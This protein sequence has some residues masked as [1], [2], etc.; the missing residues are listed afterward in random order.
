MKRIK[1]FFKLKNW[2]RILISV[3]TLASA[4]S[5]IGFGSKYYVSQNVNK[6]IEYGGGVEVVVQV[7]TNGKVADD[8]LTENVNK[9]LSDRLSGG[10]G[11]N[12]VSV[13]TEGGGKIR[14]TKSGDLNDSQRDQFLKEITNKPILTITDSE[15]KPI[16]YNGVFVEDGSLDRGTPTDWIPP[17]A[18]NQAKNVIQNNGTNV[19]ELALNNQDAVFQWTK[20]TENISKRQNKTVLM[21]LNILELIQLAKTKYASDWAAAQENLWNFVHVNNR[22]F[23]TITDPVTGQQRVERN[24][25]KKALIDIE[26]RYLISVANVNAPINSQ[27]VII[28]GNFTN[29]DA[30]NLANRINFGLSNYDLSVVYTHYLNSTLQNKAFLYAMIAG[31]LV[32]VVIAV[33]MIINYGLLGIISAIS[34]A[35]YMFLTLLIFTAIKGEYS[36][37]TIAALIIGIG[38]SVDA[39]VITFERLKSE[40]Y[41]GDSLDKSFKTSNRLSLSSIIDANITTIIIGFILF[42]LGTKEVKGFGI[43]LILSIFF[44]LVVML[45]FTRF[46]ATMIV[47]TGYFDKRLWLLGVRPKKINNPSK[48]IKRIRNIDYLRKSKWFA[49]LSFVFILTSLIVFGSVAGTSGSFWNGVNR[50]LEFSGGINILIQSKGESYGDLTLAQATEIKNVLVAKASEI[51]LLDAA[52]ITTISKASLS[53]EN[54]IVN[55]R[56]SQVLSSE[57]IE[58]IIN[59]AKNVKDDIEWNNLQILPSEAAKLVLNALIAVAVSFVGIVIYTLIRM[60]WTF[61]IAAIIGLMH[62]F[63]MVF[64]FIVITRLQVSTIIIA[65]MLSIIGLSI[66]DTIVTFDRIKEKINNEYPNQILT[67]SDIKTIVNQS[68]SDTLKRSLYTSLSTIA[69]VAILLSFGNATNFAFNIVMLFGISIGV[70]SSIFIC[71]WIWSKLEL[72]RQKRIQKRMDNKYWDISKPDEQTFPG[73]ND[74]N[75]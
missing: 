17:F 54:Y 43:T 45:V 27:K 71:S 73:I 49:L 5:A 47:G 28:S 15:L 8:T 46:L 32:F 10:T 74:F 67:K 3:L 29:N 35:L 59:L 53:T 69:A 34:I 50:S 30:L 44:T 39:N 63:I 13:S 48:V 9:F 61:A 42:Y 2:K 36:P 62:D 11:L 52:N 58:Q 75:Y 72:F 12:G 66:N 23:E 38:I 14:I 1:E 33:F 26:G 25:F 41:S 64:A 21:W 37:S 20:A 24:P 7:S 57:Q 55:I 19:V 56:T 68:I 6:S 51:N 22:P 65:A 16:F 4:A 40:I 18:A 60:N 70:Y 31:L